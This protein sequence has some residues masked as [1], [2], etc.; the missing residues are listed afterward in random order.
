MPYVQRDGSGT[1][2]GLFANPQPSFAE[3]YLP[4][5]NPEVVAFLNQ[6][7]VMPPDANA[8][9]DAGIAAAVLT[10]A[11]A[12]RDAVHAIPHSG[13]LPARFDALLIQM[14]VLA[15]AFVAMLQAQAEP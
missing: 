9:I 7:P 11:V 6:T 10:A 5:D 3:E 8:R 4:D 12:M 13:A 14:T 1:I 2:N 15:D